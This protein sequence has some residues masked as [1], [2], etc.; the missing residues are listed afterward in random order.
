MLTRGIIA[1][2]GTSSKSADETSNTPIAI[3][4]ATPIAVRIPPVKA[5]MLNLDSSSNLAD[6]FDTS[7][8]GSPCE[9]IQYTSTFW[10]TPFSLGVP[11]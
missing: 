6:T 5:N 3:Q 8:S 11:T 9:V 4:N 7:V 10:A 1:I 2:D